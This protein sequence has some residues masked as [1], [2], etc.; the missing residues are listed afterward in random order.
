MNALIMGH[1]QVVTFYQELLKQPQDVK[2]SLDPGPSVMV[3]KDF[4]VALQIHNT[5]TEERT[6]KISIRVNVALYTGKVGNTVKTDIQ[7][8]TLIPDQSK[9]TEM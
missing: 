6:V 4:E 7:V 5:S 2:F 3:G 9:S 8:L 1:S